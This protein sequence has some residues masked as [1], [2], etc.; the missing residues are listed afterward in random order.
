MCVYVLYLLYRCPRGQQ[1]F[2]NYSLSC[3]QLLNRTGATQSPTPLLIVCVFSYIYL[4][5]MQHEA[6]PLLLERRYFLQ[7][8]PNHVLVCGLEHEHI[9]Y[10]LP[11]SPPN[12]GKEGKREQQKNNSGTPAGHTPV[13]NHSPALPIRPHRSHFPPLHLFPCTCCPIPLR[14]R[15][16]A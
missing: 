11:P 15:L 4:A 12:K 10:L 5:N 2:S 1:R 16:P 14:L 7:I 13:A 9:P 6:V 8:F 3:P